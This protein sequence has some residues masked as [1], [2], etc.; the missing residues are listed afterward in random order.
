M[1]ITTFPTD[2]CAFGRFGRGSPAVVH[3]DDDTFDSGMK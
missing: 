2:C 1:N 3:S